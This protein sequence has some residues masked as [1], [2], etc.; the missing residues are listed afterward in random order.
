[1]AGH[2]RTSSRFSSG[3]VATSTSC[4]S[5]AQPHAKHATRKEL[6]VRGFVI[7]AILVLLFGAANTYLGL[8]VGLT[9]G[10]SVP[11]A[12]ISMALL[13]R[14]KDHTMVENNIVQTIGSAAM[15]AGTTIFSVP[16]LAMV[17]WWMDFPIWTIAAIV[18]GSGT[19]GVMFSIPLRRALV[20]ESNL[21]FPEG[22]AAAEVLKLDDETQEN[23]QQALEDNKRG[24]G[25][26]VAGSLAAAGLGLLQMLK[27]MASSVTKAFHVGRS[28][29]MIGGSFSLSLLGI[30]HI[31][32]PSVGIAQL[33]GIVISFFI[34]LPL[35][36]AGMTPQDGQ[37]FGEMVNSVFSSDVRMVGVGVMTVAA[38][39][40]L[41]KI[42]GPVVH[43]MKDSIA[44]SRT[45][46]QGGSVP[47][48]E[49]DL[50]YK[51]VVPITA[52]LLLLLAA[53]LWNFVSGTALS[54]AALLYVVL[55]VVFV[56]ILGMLAASVI[57]YMTGMVGS[58]NSP[59][60]GVGIVIIMVISLVLTLLSKNA[61]EA[62]SL[63]V[64]AYSLFCLAT[65]FVIGG[66]AQDNM[67]DLKTGYLVNATPWK[68]Q[69]ALIFGVAV[70]AVTV[71][72]V[73]NLLMKSFGFLGPDGAVVGG[74]TGDPAQALQAPQ[75]GLMA[76][77]AQ[78]I[79]GSNFDW[80]RFGLGL[81]IGVVVVVADELL[82]RYTRFTLPALAVGMGMYLMVSTTL[83]IFAGS[84]IGLI[85]DRW[86]QNRRDA[87]SA[88]RLGLLAAVGLIVGDSLFGIVS[89][90]II[91]GTGN[92][93][94][95]AIMPDGWEPFGI[96]LGLVVFFGVGI[97]AHVYA[98]SLA[99]K[100]EEQTP[101]S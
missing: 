82:K 7:G 33:V 17:G 101:R 65:C 53:V 5:S 92:P 79:V 70:G 97:W 45:R 84:M 68:Q 39:F 11:S 74:T 94:P 51:Y 57:S 44:S 56:L 75:A 36:T 20:V 43:G 19:L 76:A 81:T 8:K 85:Y 80:S 23:N 100:A 73:L 42:A 67:Q 90:A 72:T 62:G 28:G 50:P 9:F 95:L 6:T 93:A 89:A 24:V 35:F 69:V 40:T 32:G 13:R 78:G 87:E 54:H 3:R 26:I 77:I 18:F 88:K 55:G 12:V 96:V 30:G 48:N 22:R 63:D 2:E 4:Q 25:A 14:F 49:R 46:A 10:I 16:A 1:M 91:G 59:A 66:I 29:I 27:V 99:V 41:T 58:S 34:L 15:A 38:L 83:M 21:P 47:V 31:V 98:G 60:S 71:P 37:T 86:A 64:V 61:P 52:A